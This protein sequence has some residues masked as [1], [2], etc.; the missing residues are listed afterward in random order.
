MHFP[1]RSYEQYERKIRQGSHALLSNTK[2]PQNEGR[3]WLHIYEHFYRHGR[4]G[5]Y[6]EGLVSSEEEVR[7]RVAA[8]DLVIDERLATFFRNHPP[9]C[10]A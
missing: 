3:T 5:D 10:L 7:R 6:Y 4:L 8:G 2:R 1:V 9:A